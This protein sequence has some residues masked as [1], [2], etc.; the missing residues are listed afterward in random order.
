MPFHRRDGGGETPEA[1]GR[2][3]LEE[4]LGIRADAPFQH[5]GAVHG[6]WDGQQHRVLLFTMPLD[7][8]PV[9]QRDNR[10]IIG[11]QLVPIDDL[12]D[13]PLTCAV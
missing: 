12:E 1:A 2:R 10:E 3:E 9:L 6:L 4:E 11:A 7:H 5:V 8:L 13:L